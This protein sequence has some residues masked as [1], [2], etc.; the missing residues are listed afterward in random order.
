MTFSHNDKVDISSESDIVQVRTTVRET[1]IRIGFNATDVTRIVTAASELA[2]NIHRFAG[3]GVMYYTSLDNGDRKGIE[4]TFEDSGPGIENIEI[5]MEEGYTTGN[6][7]GLGLPGARRLMDEMEI[8]SQ[9]DK[10]TTVRV[11]KWLR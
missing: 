1:A 4:L 5:A 7:L 9:I 6:G 11:I 2:R 8:T 3:S 10:G